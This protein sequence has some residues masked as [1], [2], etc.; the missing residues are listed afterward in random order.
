MPS[1]PPAGPGNAPEPR[2]LTDLEA[3]YEVRFASE[4]VALPPGGVVLQETLFYPTGGGQP[5]D[6]GTLTTPDGT[7]VPVVDVGHQG[8]LTVHRV[9]KKGA[10]ALQRGMTVRGEIDWSRRFT[11]MRLHTSQHLLSALAFRR[12]GVR[13]T[14]AQLSGRGAYLDLERPLPEASSVTS[15][16][17]EANR[18]FFARHVPVHLRFV[19]RE[20]LLQIP[21]RSDPGKLPPSV[22]RV[23]LVVIGEE[24]LA[25][26]GGTHLRDTM[27]V[28]G[29]RG[30]RTEPRPGGGVRLSYELAEPSS[31][32]PSP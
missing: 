3:G 18:D 12:F 24:D 23:R 8:G 21:N 4:V 27:E 20:E 32:A 26:C 17:E 5:C 29:I 1:E 19:T 11:H 7:V 31:S 6:L 22:S 16:E 14:S 28:G 13:T 10:Q 2:Y 15:L 25:P 9:G 30:L